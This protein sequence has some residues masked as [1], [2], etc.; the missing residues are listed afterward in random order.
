MDKYKEL[1]EQIRRCT[2]GEHSSCQRC[3][4]EKDALCMVH[5]MAE[6]ADAIEE[7]IE[8]DR[9]YLITNPVLLEKIKQREKKFW[10]YEVDG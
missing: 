6:A 4:R 9:P 10:G 8:A 2:T 7:L 5:F 3:R 1:I